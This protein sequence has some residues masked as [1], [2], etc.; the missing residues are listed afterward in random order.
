MFTVILAD[1][2]TLETI[3][4][5]HLFLDACVAAR[6][7]AYCPWDTRASNPALAVHA[8][9]GLI[10]GRQRWRAVIVCGED[11]IHLQNPFDTVCYRDPQQQA[12]EADAD[13]FARRRAARFAAF[14]AAARQPLTRLGAYLCTQPIVS[15]GLNRTAQHASAM[16]SG[17]DGYD[18]ENDAYSIVRASQAAVYDEFAEYQAEALYRQQLWEQI[19]EGVERNFELP[20]E[21]LCISKR[22]YTDEKQALDSIWKPHLESEYSE[23]S[24]YNLYFD[25]MRYLLYDIVPRNH[26]RYQLEELR[27]LYAMLTV[28][29]NELPQG[30]LQPGR[31]FR[32]DCKNDDD[33]IAEMMSLYCA[34][35]DAS[36]E[37]LEG[38]IEQYRYEAKQPI[39]DFEAARFQDRPQVT[40]QIP[41][42]EFDTDTLYID[43]KTL[44]MTGDCPDVEKNKWT[45]GVRN[46]HMA[47]ARY[48]RL[49]VRA[50][51]KSAADMHQLAQYDVSMAARLNEFQ[52]EDLERVVGNA[53][54]AMAAADIRRPD[55]YDTC[56]K[57]LEPV[58]KGIRTKNA[59]R[60]MRTP[61]VVLGVVLLVVTLL[62][63]LPFFLA[64]EAGA[65]T[66]AFSGI[67]TLVAVGV[68]ALSMVICLLF[69][70]RAHRIGWGDYNGHINTI[71]GEVEHSMALFSKYLTDACCAI[72]GFAALNF[73]REHEE[74]R[75]SRSRL[76]RKH[77]ADMLQLREEVVD[78][79]GG[80]IRT[81]PA[82]EQPERYDYDYQRPVTYSYPLPMTAG[83]SRQMEFIQ[84]GVTV[85]VPCR[86]MK[87]ILVQREELYD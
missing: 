1:R 20:Q 28:A 13:Y 68:V 6:E 16:H 62:G 30:A 36:V 86:I 48:L 5:Q 34:K 2:E 17:Q 63:F 32:L 25:K 54:L 80:Y 43:N 58:E 9:P 75:H 27:Y 40:V 71:R 57:R 84:K 14:D 66:M 60:S 74:P 26:Q 44:G 77:I 10:A 8:L 50:L 49:P 64:N 35:L 38:I 55:D 7:I 12:D 87:H 41:A 81:L 69:M 31:V 15:E 51:K 53:E 29:C 76:L 23:F 78:V 37:Y 85:T 83:G 42:K 61:I 72:R 82:D 46:S 22:C 11:S 47:L 73:Y 45:V 52:A 59:H 21:I 67:V 56:I 70:Q 79:F 18:Y 19:L 3:R 39:S 65:K 24:R 33:Q 4:E